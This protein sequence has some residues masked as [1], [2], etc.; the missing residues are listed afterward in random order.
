M[1]R[2][3]ISVMY[4]SNE[5]CRGGAEEH[6]L[7]L[8]RGLDRQYFRLHW[9]CPPELAA[10]V[11]VDV[12]GDVEL[13]RVEFRRPSH[14]SSAARLAQLIRRCH[15]DILHSHL[16]YASL[17]ASPVGWLCRVPVVME[18]PHVREAWRSGWKSR[19][20]VDR[21]AGTFVD[22][23]IAVSQANARYLNEEK[24]LPAHKIS[25]IHNGRDIEQFDPEH[26]VPAG[27][28]KELGFGESDPVLAVVGRLEPQ[29]GHCVLFDA[30]SIVRQE[31][32][33]VRLI[34][35]GEGSLRAELGARVLALGL[36][37]AVR[38]VGF[39][40]QPA[41]W[42][43]VADFTVLPSFYEG[44]P[45]AAIDSMAAGRA[46]VGTAVDGTPEVVLDGKTGLLVPAGDAARLAD[47]MG[48]LLR[49]PRLCRE[50]GRNARKFVLE[51]FTQQ[52]QIQQ[53]QE[54]YIDALEQRSLSSS[55]I[56]SRISRLTASAQVGEHREC[57]TKS[58]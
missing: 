25:V 6:I 45:L 39:Q 28:R 36:K 46:V 24:G 50:L 21:L 4:F 43:A 19:Y 22:H 13:L 35:L 53:T 9:V 57:I 2:D 15:V 38:L 14:F 31:F 5:D 16:F 29:K 17:F 8:L 10:Q 1:K 52:R 58:Q 23:Y 47:A 34:C 49:D 42:L 26:A 40:S 18:T 41:N 30:L 33:G 54:L 51:K 3:L 32:P 27:M 7:T 56:R 48:R 55:R 20:F 37:D 11:A 12:P 44:L